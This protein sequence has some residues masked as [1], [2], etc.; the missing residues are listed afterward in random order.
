MT[1]RPMAVKWVVMMVEK[2]GG[3]RADTWAELKEQWKVAL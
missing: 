3:E 1:V 2:L